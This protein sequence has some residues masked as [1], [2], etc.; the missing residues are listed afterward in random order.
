ML[1]DYTLKQ[2]AVNLDH[3]AAAFGADRKNYFVNK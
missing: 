3:R 2:E 1:R